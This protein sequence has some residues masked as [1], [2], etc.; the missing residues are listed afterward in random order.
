MAFL[1]HRKSLADPRQLEGTLREHHL[2]QKNT[3][4]D[5]NGHDRTED[6]AV[7]SVLGH[8]PPCSSTKGATGHTLGAAGIVEALVSW[9]ALEHGFLP[10][11]LNTAEVDPELD[12]RI[13]LATEQAAPQVALSNSFGFGGSNCSLLLKRLQ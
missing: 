11:T 3:E 12:A 8:V 5:R 4:D 6:R 9:L 10:G 13:V 2:L 1:G 7:M